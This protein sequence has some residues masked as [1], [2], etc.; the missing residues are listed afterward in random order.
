MSCVDFCFDCPLEK[1]KESD[2]DECSYPIYPISEQ[3]Q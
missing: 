2:C 1:P 3:E